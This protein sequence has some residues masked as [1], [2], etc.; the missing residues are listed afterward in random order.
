MWS[1]AAYSL[2]Q[3]KSPT[4]GKWGFVEVP[5]GTVHGVSHLGSWVD[6][7]PKTA[8]DPETAFHFLAWLHNKQNTIKQALL[9]GDSYGGDPTRIDAYQDRALVTSNIPGTHIHQFTRFPVTL[10]AMEH[11]LPRPFFP[12][13][14]AWEVAITSDL[15]ALQLG[16]TSVASALKSAEAHA[17]AVTQGMPKY[18]PQP[19]PKLAAPKSKVS[20]SKV[21]ASVE[22]ELRRK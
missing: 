11:T 8:K 18:V 2:E 10:R 5:A 16:Q 22:A 3:P 9:P 7:I 14:E 4:K 20:L 19:G 13:E 12:K 1:W 21:A 17:A 6:V 15:S